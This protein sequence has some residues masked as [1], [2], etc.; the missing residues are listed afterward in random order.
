[1]ISLVQRFLSQ[2][3]WHLSYSQTTKIKYARSVGSFIITEWMLFFLTGSRWTRSLTSRI[4][5]VQLGSDCS[6]D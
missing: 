5:F 1:M 6:I 4:L 2:R 3:R